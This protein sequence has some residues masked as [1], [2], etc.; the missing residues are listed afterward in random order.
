[1]GNIIW[2]ENKFFFIK[3]KRRICKTRKFFK[4]NKQKKNTWHV[5][6]REVQGKKKCSLLGTFAAF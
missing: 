6:E 2:S 4:I 5:E 1:M 3:G